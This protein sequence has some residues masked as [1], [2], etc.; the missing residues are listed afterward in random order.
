MVLLRCVTLE[1]GRKLLLDIHGGICG[2][3]VAPRA[4]VGKAFRNGFYWLTTLTDAWD[5]IK[6]CKG[7]QYYAKQS[8]LPTHAL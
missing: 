3:H 1:D 7:Y 4:L 5:L 2:H 8:Y 6:T